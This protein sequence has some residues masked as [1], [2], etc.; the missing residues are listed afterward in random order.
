MM[1]I[2]T[3]PKSVFLYTYS[4]NDVSS[5]TLVCFGVRVRLWVSGVTFSVKLF[6]SKCI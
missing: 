6:S 2:H 5:K 4:K 1:F 3:S